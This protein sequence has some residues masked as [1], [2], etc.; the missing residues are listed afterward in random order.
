MRHYV[1]RVVAV[2]LP[3]HHGA[4]ALRHQ[5]ALALAGRVGGTLSATTRLVGLWAYIQTILHI[6]I[7]L[8]FYYLKYLNIN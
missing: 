3:R 8:V 1:L 5:L 2:H 7:Y 6:V 4:A